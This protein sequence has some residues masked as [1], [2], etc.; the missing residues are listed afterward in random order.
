MKKILLFGLLSSFS[1]ASN[2]CSEYNCGQFA[3]R[4]IAQDSNSWSWNRY[5]RGSAVYNGDYRTLTNGK[6]F[7]VN[8][9]YNNGRS[10]WA[11]IKLTRYNDFN[12]IVF[13]DYPN[14]CRG[15]R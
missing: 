6:A 7:K 12:C 8:Y 4:I 13:H 15:I 9:T 3:D 2:F 14:T 10:G 5:D 11:L 1:I